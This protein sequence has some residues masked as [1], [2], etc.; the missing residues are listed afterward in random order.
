THD[1]RGQGPTSRDSTPNDLVST[2]SSSA[3]PTATLQLQSF[4]IPLTAF[5]NATS[6]LCRT[7]RA[8]LDATASFTVAAQNLILALVQVLYHI[9]CLFVARAFIRLK[10]NMT[11]TLSSAMHA[12]RYI[13]IFQGNSTSV[14][15]HKGVLSGELV[16]SIA[17]LNTSTRIS[18]EVQ[19]DVKRTTQIPTDQS[20]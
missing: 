4:I 16:I 6:E 9:L 1:I 20:L 8:F 13:R 19:A 18:I 2:S 17:A 15:S 11:S 14:D 5:S 10:K 3:S 12:G 7:I